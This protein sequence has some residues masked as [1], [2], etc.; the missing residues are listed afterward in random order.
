MLFVGGGNE[1]ELAA[2]VNRGFDG[3]EELGE[4]GYEVGFVDEGEGCR[5]RTAR[6]GWKRPGAE[7]LE[8]IQRVSLEWVTALARR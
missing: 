2:G 3:V 6:S 4:V 8:R 1:E 7:P 5:C